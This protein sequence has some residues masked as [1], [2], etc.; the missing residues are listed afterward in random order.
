[1]SKHHDAIKNDPR[2]KAARAEVL[3]RDGYACTE[4]GSPE[5]LE[6][7]H[8]IELHVDPGLAFEVENLRTLCRDCHEARTAAGTVGAIERHQ[9]INPKYLDVLAPI[10]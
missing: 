8:I 9:W 2:W 3:E 10:L 1:M 6:V 4:C 5:R 7:D